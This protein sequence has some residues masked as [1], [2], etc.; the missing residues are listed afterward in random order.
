M[1]RSALGHSK[2]MCAVYHRENQ[3][4][5]GGKSQDHLRD[6]EKAFDAN[7]SI[8]IKTPRNRN[9]LIGNS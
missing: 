9:R 4:T 3:Q 1:S 5:G 2:N 8:P 7:I 6:V